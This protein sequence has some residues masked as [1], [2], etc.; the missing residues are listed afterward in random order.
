VEKT[1]ARGIKGGRANGRATL[2]MATFNAIKWN[3][4]FKVF[5]DR[6]RANGKKFKV[7]WVATMRKMSAILNVLIKTNTP[8]SR[9]GGKRKMYKNATMD[10]RT[11]H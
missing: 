2:S 7:A 9:K 1:G 11:H 5:V 3:H 8:G 10:S 6:L 4:T